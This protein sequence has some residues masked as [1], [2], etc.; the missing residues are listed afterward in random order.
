MYI[1]TCENTFEDMMCCIYHAWEKALKVG[2]GCVR[3][4]KRGE[5]QISLFDEYIYV[6]YNE[7][8]Y[9]KVV[10]S[11]RHKISEEAYACVYYACLSSEQDALDTAYRFLIKGFKIGSDITFMRNDP[12]VMRIKVYAGRFCTRQDI[13]WSLQ[14][15]IQLVTKYMCVILN[16]KA[17]LYMKFLYI[18]LT[19]CLLRTG[20]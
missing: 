7:E 10:R 3:L 14:G 13:L 1:F 11:I 20:L 2:H 15:L 9:K 16:Q 4:E 6:E 17:M 19:E 12:D 5:E 18:L 8:E